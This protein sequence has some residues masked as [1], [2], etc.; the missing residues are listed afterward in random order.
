MADRADQLLL[1]S[2]GT[3]FLARPPEESEQAAAPHHLCGHQYADRL[4]VRR[5]ESQ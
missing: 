5:R 4:D 1:V 2:I 3:G